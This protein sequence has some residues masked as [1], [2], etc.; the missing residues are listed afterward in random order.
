MPKA[1]PGNAPGPA[2]FL[3]SLDAADGATRLAD[4]SYTRSAL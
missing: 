3:G 1:G 4:A 2:L